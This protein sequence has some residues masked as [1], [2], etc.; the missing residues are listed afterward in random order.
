VRARVYSFAEKIQPLYELLDWKWYDCGIPTVEDIYEK[1]QELITRFKEQDEYTTTAGIM[2][3]KEYDE[4]ML[5]GITLAFVVDDTVW[6]SEVK[7]E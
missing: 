3:K 2:I 1:T 4:G 7:Y 5:Q 6:L